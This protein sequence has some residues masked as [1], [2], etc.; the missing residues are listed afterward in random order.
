[1][2]RLQTEK[3]PYLQM[4]AGNPVDWYPWGQEAF[5]AARSQNK[6]VFLSIG[7]SSCHWCHV[8][9]HESFEDA[10][11]AALLNGHFISIK[12]DKEERPDIDVVYMDAVQ[13]TTGSGG[14]PM[15]L[16]LTPDGEPF[17][18]LTYLPKESQGSMM[19]L[20][21]LLSRSA[22]LW[23]QDSSSL[24]AAAHELTA[25]MRELCRHQP[26]A[27]K[28]TPALLHRA[29][30]DFDAAYDARWGGFGGAP[31]FPSPHNLLF[32][33][34]MYERD[35]DAQALAMVTG[36]LDAMYR[37]GLFDHIG[38]GFCR[39]SVDERWLVPHFEKMLYDNALLLWAYAE[40]Y[41]LTANP[42]YAQVA[43]RTASYV[44]GEMTG[45][46][47][48]FF[49]AQDADSEGR[50]GA[51]Y[52]F[53]PQEIQS[54]LGAE[55]TSFFCQWYGVTAE[56]NFEGS[57]IPNL[58]DNPQ[59]AAEPPQLQAMRDQVYA[60]RRS[61]MPLRRDDK[62]LTAWNCLMIAGLCAAAKALQEPAYLTAAQRAEAF[63]AQ[64]LAD[65]AGGLL[66]RYRDGEAKG[67]GVLADYAGY[68]LA[69]SAL[70]DATRDPTY[71]DR[72]EGTAGQMLIRFGSTRQAGFYLYDKQGERLITRPKEL[73]DGATP[74]GNAL[75]ALVLLRLA[76]RTGKAQCRQ[77]ADRQ[78]RLMA[79]AAQEHPMGHGFSLYAMAEALQG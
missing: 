41:R 44:I 13:L 62:V 75:A 32:L 7:Y 25:K 48:E 53:T 51:Y 33:L 67:S 59:F 18:A 64:E 65:D 60:Y 69:L 58:L 24:L 52:L 22:A 17:V 46:E 68:S 42:L 70:H 6:P 11:I 5:E 10:E 74:S 72:A 3:S 63:L 40:A 78:L 23:R 38:G 49:S 26:E 14:W 45:S 21:Y 2:N 50:E 31:K 12:V 28:P 35:G 77:Q 16:L 56:G 47:G 79:G 4:H 19:G 54:Q 34:S 43:R 29:V 37:G 36:T 76:D 61:R 55:E 39:Y 30:S 8:I 57:N 20:K 27:A 9:A 66:I 15:T 71:L 1:M 73:W